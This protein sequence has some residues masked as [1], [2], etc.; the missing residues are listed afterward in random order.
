MNQIIVIH[1]YKYEGQW[2]FDDEAVG[3]RREAFVAGADKIIDKMV[4]IENIPNAAHGFTLLFSA[5]PFPGYQEEFKWLGQDLGG[6][7]YSSPNLKLE[8]WLC[9][10]LLRYFD[11]APERIYAQF[12]AESRLTSG[13]SRR[14][15]RYPLTQH[16][17]AAAE[18]RALG[19]VNHVR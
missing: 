18:P 15:Q 19:S 10:A 9:P 1:P 3:L 14:L 5:S 16:L 11:A 13:C 8:G 17:K 4:E 7:T 12:K 2:V 6:N